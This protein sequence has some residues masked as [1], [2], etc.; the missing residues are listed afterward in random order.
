[1]MDR[2]VKLR[3]AFQIL[4][5]ATSYVVYEDDAVAVL[6]KALKEVHQELH[7]QHRGILQ[8]WQLATEPSEPFVPHLKIIGISFL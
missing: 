3:A 4:I 2:E 7:P 5:S 6:E 1:M 8:R